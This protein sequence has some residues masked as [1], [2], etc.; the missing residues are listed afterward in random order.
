MPR[1][2]LRSSERIRTTTKA[3][4]ISMTWRR[5]LSREIGHVLVLGVLRR[6]RI[7]GFF[8]HLFGLDDSREEALRDQVERGGPRAKATLEAENRGDSNSRFYAIRERAI[9][10]GYDRRGD[11]DR[12][13]L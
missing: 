13:R 6:H 12:R 2:G 10:A 11:E 9:A 1:A 8:S 3:M 5:K 7:M 4:R